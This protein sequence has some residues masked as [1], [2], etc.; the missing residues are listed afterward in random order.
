MFAITDYALPPEVAEQIADELS[1]ISDRRREPGKR[2]E[3]F[4]L[5][6]RRN[7]RPGKRTGSHSRSM[8]GRAAVQARSR[9]RHLGQAPFTGG[10]KSSF[11]FSFR[12]VGFAVTA[13]A[14]SDAEA[15]T[16]GMDRRHDAEHAPPSV[17][18]SVARVA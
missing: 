2:S 9:P 17:V 7:A 14:A 4:A 18:R 6:W 1:E 16:A 13:S 8:A 11:R 3:P 15:Q 12:V 10:S 5:N